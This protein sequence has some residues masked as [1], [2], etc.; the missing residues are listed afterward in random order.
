MHVS[1]GDK[2]TGDHYLISEKRNGMINKKHVIEGCWVQGAC[3]VGVDRVNYRAN[4]VDFRAVPLK[5]Y[6]VTPH[7]RN[8]VISVTRQ[9]IDPQKPWENDKCSHLLYDVEACRDKSYHGSSSQASTHA[10]VAL[11]QSYPVA[12]KIYQ[13]ECQNARESG[14]V[15]QREFVRKYCHRNWV[16]R[17]DP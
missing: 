7:F 11:E 13:Q 10:R 9:K 2:W 15:N 8:G 12:G 4:A 6:R 3:D 1:T 14:K 5:G 16:Y 17:V